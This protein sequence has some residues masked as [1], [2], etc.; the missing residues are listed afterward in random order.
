[1]D[2]TVALPRCSMSNLKAMPGNN[3]R[4]GSDSHEMTMASLSNALCP[5][6][7]VEQMMP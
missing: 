7:L 6:A 1:M 2:S 3:C 5:R 4:R